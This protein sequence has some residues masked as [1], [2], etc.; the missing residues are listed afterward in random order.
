MEGVELRN[1]IRLVGLSRLSRFEPFK[2]ILKGSCIERAQSEPIRHT[3]AT[4]DTRRYALGLRLLRVLTWLWVTRR[5]TRQ[6]TFGRQGHGRRARSVTFLVLRLCT[7]R[8]SHVLVVAITLLYC[9][10]RALPRILAEIFTPVAFVTCIIARIESFGKKIR[11]RSGRRGGMMLAIE[12]TRF[13][14]PVDMPPIFAPPRS[15]TITLLF[16]RIVLLIGAVFFGFL[17][18]R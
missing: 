17:L 18:N 15:P 11:R 12:V 9:F 10:I 2:S 16:L 14:L 8:G 4:S 3:V 6:A 13:L 5:I 7:T 1:W